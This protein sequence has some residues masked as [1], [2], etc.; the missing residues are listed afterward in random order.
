MKKY[1]SYILLIIEAVAIFA[2]CMNA[3]KKKANHWN[4]ETA[5]PDEMQLT[6]ADEVSVLDFSLLVVVFVPVHYLQFDRHNLYKTKI[7]KS[8][9][10]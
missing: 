7:K 3:A 10:Q 5:I 8:Q 1:L 4:A 9:K 2:L 6:I